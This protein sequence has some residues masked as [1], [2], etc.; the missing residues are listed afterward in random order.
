MDK[1]LELAVISPELEFK[2]RDAQCLSSNRRNS[3]CI[4]EHQGERYFVKKGKTK[5]LER[6]YLAINFFGSY[7]IINVANVVY[8]KDGCLATRFEEGLIELSPE[9]I[10]RALWNIHNFGYISGSSLPL[11]LHDFFSRSRIKKQVVEEYD[12][13]KRVVNIKSIEEEMNRTEQMFGVL[14]RIPCHGDAHRGNI[15]HTS[16]AMPFLLDLEFSHMNSPTFDVA[17]N[18]F[19]EPENMERMVISYLSLIDLERFGGISK[20]NVAELILTDCLRICLH[21]IT[22]SKNRLQGIHFENRLDHIKKVLDKVM[23][24]LT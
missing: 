5:N 24:Y 17:T 19:A 6:E 20:D 2:L 14:Q 4:V 9:E 21:D 1:S 11:S 18:I 16:T 3:S 13:L 7:P 15:Y 23:N 12:F 8:F 10:A 22:K